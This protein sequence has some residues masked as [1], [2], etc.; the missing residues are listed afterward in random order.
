MA[1]ILRFIISSGSKKKELRLDLL[2]TISGK[3]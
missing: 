3:S 1:P 2:C